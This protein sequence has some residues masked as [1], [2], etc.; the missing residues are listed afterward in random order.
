VSR[1]GLLIGAGA[2][3]VV[4]VGGAYEAVEHDVL[5]G[6]IRLNRLLGRGGAAPPIPDVEPGPVVSGS[7]SSA[8]RGGV[9]VGWTVAYPPGSARGD[10]LPVCIALHGRGGSH[11]WPFDN[12]S[13]QYFLADAVTN[14]GVPA[15]VVATV[16]GGSATNWHPRADGD[17]PQA[18][19]VNEFLPLLRRRGLSVERIGLWGWSLGGYGA[20]LLASKLGASRVAAVVAAS[21]ALW[22]SFDETEPDVFD[23]AADFARNDVFTREGELAGIPLRIDVGD[24]DPF[25]PAVTEFRSQLSPTPAGGVTSGFHDDAFWMRVAPAEIEFLGTNLA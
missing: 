11:S 13:L 18:M 14:G 23:D 5:P 8:A 21:P 15:F 22:R 24:N 16:D 4:A 2:A 20:L 25:A 10:H 1:R 17:D 7:F 3:V 19:V 12:L 9:D 6:R